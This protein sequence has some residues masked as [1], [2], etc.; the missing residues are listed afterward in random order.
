ISGNALVCA[1]TPGNYSITAV[2]GAS[3]YNWTVPAGWTINSGQ[4]TTSILVTSGITGGNICVNAS[5]SCGTSS[6]SCQAITIQSAP[7]ATSSVIGNN[8]L[9]QGSTGT[10][11]TQTSPGAASYNWTV[12]AG[13]TI[14][15]GQGTTSI[16]V[17][18]GNS[19]GNICV[20]AVNS[21][22]TSNPTCQFINISTFS[23]GGSVLSNS[24]VCE[25]SN[26][27]TLTLSGYNGSILKWQSST[28]NGL[29]WLDI[30]NTTSTQ[31]YNNLINTTLY[32]AIVQSGVCTS[33]TSVYA[34]ITV[35]PAVSGG[36]LASSASYCSTTNGDVLKLTGQSSTINNWEFSIDNGTTWNTIAN[37][38]DSLIYTNISQ[39]TLYRVVLVGAGGGTCPGNVSSIATI[40]INPPTNGGT[41][42]N[43]ATV[44]SGNNMGTLYLTGYSGTILNWEVS[45]D[46]SSW[47]VLSN[48]VDTF[49]YN[50]L[51]TTSWFRVLLQSANCASAYSVPAKITVDSKSLGGTVNSSTIACMGSNGNTLTLSG[52]NG[53]IQNWLESNG[54]VI[55]NSIPNTSNTYNYSNLFS[56]TYYSVVVQNGV[57]P[58]DTANV[59]IITI[60]PAVVGGTISQ[61]ATVCAA[62][63]NGTLTL[64]GHSGNIQQWELSND[65][66][67][68]WVNLANTTTSQ[69]YNNL[70]LTTFYRA[71]VASGQCGTAYSDTVEITVIPKSQGGSINGNGVTVCANSNSGTLNLVNYTGNVQSWEF[72][73]N[74]GSTWNSVSNTTDSLNYTNLT[75]STIY[76]AIVQNSFCNA[77]T[78]TYATVTVTPQ[79]VGGTVVI[80]NTVCSGINN[81][82]LTLTGNVGNVLN[83]EVS[84]DGGSTWNVLSNNSDTLT[85]VNITQ[86]SMYRARI[87]SGNVCADA[88]STVATITTVSQ[89]IGGSVLSSITV[90]G[91]MNSD[92]LILNGYNGNVVFWQ[93]STNNGTSWNNIINTTDSLAFN[94][95]TTT[96]WYRAF[97]QNSVCPSVGST[98]AV[99]TVNDSTVA[100]NL[101]SSATVCSGLNNN[102]LELTGYT[103]SIQGWE[104][105][106]DGGIT[107]QSLSNTSSTQV[108]NNLTSSVQYRVRVKSGICEQK[109]TDIAYIEVDAMSNAGTLAESISVCATEN[110]DTLQLNNYTGN[111]TNWLYSENNGTNWNQVYSGI[112]P[113]DSTL[114]DTLSYLNISSTIWYMVVVQNGVCPA[115]TSNIA[116]IQ[117]NQT[118]DLLAN[119]DLIWIKGGQ[120]TTINISS[121]DS[122]NWST[123]TLISSAAQGLA[124]NNND[125]TISYI[126]NQGYLGRDSLQY[127]ICNMCG[128]CDT[129]TVRMEVGLFIPTGFSPDGDGYNDFFEISGI[130]NYPENT[131]TIFNRWGNVVYNATPY[132]NEW[133]GKSSNTSMTISGDQL[134]DGTY[135]YIIQLGPNE[136]PINGYV[137]LRRGN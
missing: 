129:A 47:F 23:D 103:G 68:T 22:G 58:A 56:T 88:Y 55:W 108:Y 91:D 99:V 50:N 115:D 131:I 78:S 1:S 117:I 29:S 38:T 119:D 98:I 104:S 5:N 100:G 64:S 42:I 26:S 48:N 76:R 36:T 27:G 94:N 2:S 80:N 61:D 70:S 25:G 19:S 101:A 82:T 15:S 109:I 85:Y 128:I 114:P 17:T 35:L 31:S 33:D 105:S 124:S 79:T 90:C 92:T 72:S 116:V 135:F 9:C 111:I 71:V 6:N 127:Q 62:S 10:Y 112:A 95:L 133:N 83:W 123:V 67:F 86:T 7:N 43:N 46:S 51:S 122:G 32:Q 30:A 102:I 16:S 45:T 93:S 21:C 34:E 89:S 84:T 40:T 110:G 8:T 96:T 59:A 20:E 77:D 44:C 136:K 130:S 54:G 73:T 57:C 113:G 24:T 66:G 134:I 28:D 125:G 81:G 75:N 65:G 97:V 107:W 132:K 41:V 4:G 121:N 18:F 13:A 39:T 87:R 12:P 3:S 52:Y 63:N 118:G 126:P 60:D 137:E 106:L 120:N 14:N 74:G 69:S 37:T 49:A 11:S 53:Q